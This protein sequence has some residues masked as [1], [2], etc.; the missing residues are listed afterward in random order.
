MIERIEE[1]LRGMMHSD[2]SPAVREAASSSLGR[3]QAKRSVGSSLQTLRTGSVADRI[4]IVH[5][6]EEIG[7][8]EG[9][10]LLVTALS[11][12]EA[13]V[14]GAAARALSVFPSVPVLKVLAERLPKEQGVVLGNILE[15]LG[16]SRRKELAPVIGRYVG[17]NDE[18][19]SGK[20]V[21]AFALV[22]GKEDWEKILAQA[23]SG[24]ANVREAVAAA[25]SE[26]SE[27]DA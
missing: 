11:D 23:G 13:Q 16:M 19:V 9:V 15:T 8:R 18:F 24:S 14:R 6:A 20:A 2:P 3:L 10:T 1:I 7:G 22:A 26:W 5:S 12:Q 25:L 17:H 21:K 4:R 27:G